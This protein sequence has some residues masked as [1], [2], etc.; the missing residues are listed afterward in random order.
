[1]A[2]D[3]PISRLISLRWN[4]TEAR[5]YSAHHLRYFAATLK[6]PRSDYHAE[7]LVYANELIIMLKIDLMKDSAP[8]LFFSFAFL[9]RY[10]L[11]IQHF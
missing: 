6:I 3:V 4:F 1:M 9:L 2:S 10:L 5:L 7:L 8:E 11:I